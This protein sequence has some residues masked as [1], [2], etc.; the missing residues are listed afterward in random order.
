MSNSDHLPD[1]R[2]LKDRA[3][4]VR[5][6][7]E[8]AG[9]PMSHAQA[10]E[11]LAHDLG[12]RDWNTLSAAAQKGDRR[13]HEG[14]RVAGRY[15]GQVFEGRVHRAEAD[16]RYTRLTVDF[17]APVD[18]VRFEGFS[19][20]RRRVSARIGPDGTTAERTSDGQP[21]MVIGPAR[22]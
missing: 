8:A 6:Q 4:A 19:A 13:L 5:R 15:L 7:A 3:R 9:T 16:G 20:L 12:Y 21:H 2:V 18:V 1:I 14:D 17:D 10:L 11:R 22:L